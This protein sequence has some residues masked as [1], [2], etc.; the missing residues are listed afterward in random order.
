MGRWFPSDQALKI[1]YL[2]QGR[3]KEEQKI[4]QRSS[5]HD[6]QLPV[7]CPSDCLVTETFIFK[8]CADG[9]MIH[10]QK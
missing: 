2:H 6:D 1:E 9:R 4:P 10:H 5:R 8:D 7:H 3:V